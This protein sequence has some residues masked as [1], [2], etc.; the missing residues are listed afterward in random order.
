MSAVPPS[1]PLLQPVSS[2]E[3]IQYIDVLRGFALYGV[4]LANIIWMACMIEASG[5]TVTV[6]CVM[7]SPAFIGSL[8]S[9]VENRA[10]A[11]SSLSCEGLR[12]T[13]RRDARN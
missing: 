3:R 10:Q 5:S 11:F 4:L 1:R 8:L 9:G 13:M 6:D 7:T 12:N 2:G